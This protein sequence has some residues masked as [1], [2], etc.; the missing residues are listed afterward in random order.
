MDSGFIDLRHRG[1]TSDGHESFWPSFTDIMTVVVMIFMLASTVLIL[2]NYELVAEL[3]RTIDAER[4]ASSMAREAQAT[5]ATLEEQLAML[6][7]ELSQLRIQNLRLGEESSRQASRLATQEQELLAGETDRLRLTTALQGAERQASVL[8]DEKRQREQELAQLQDAYTALDTRQGEL[9]AQ[10]AQLE[11][12]HRQQLAELGEVKQVRAGLAQQL[13]S[14]EGEYSS[15]RQEYEKLIRPARTAQGKQVAEVRFHK[16]DGHA[17]IQLRSP[18]ETGYKV[19]PR[20]VLH[21]RLAA[22]KARHGADLY[23]KIIIPSDSGL[24][25]NEAWNFTRELLDRYDYYYQ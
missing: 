10:F 2:R 21:E 11:A 6:Q 18:D 23:V 22:L 25:Y 20:E 1:A 19:V 5:S 13:A 7:H 15:L 8:A 16:A 3:Q 24:S 14:L 12:Q 17:R 4:A 9:L